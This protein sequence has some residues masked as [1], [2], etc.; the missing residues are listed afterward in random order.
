MS[1]ELDLLMGIHSVSSPVLDQVMLGITYASTHAAL[2]L[3]MSALMMC[4][5][6]YHKAGMAII[7]AVAVAYVVGDLIFKPMIARDRPC[8]LADFTLLVPIPE[9][10]SFPSGH[11]MSSF[12]AAT[13]LLMFHRREGCIAMVFAA[14]VGLSR[15][16]LFVHWPTDVLAGAFLG[17]AVAYLVV[18]FMERWI[19]SF[20]DMGGG[21]DPESV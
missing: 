6:R 3:V 2:W 11:T 18:R 13:A 7:V 9:T 12:A 1:I 14:L 10:Y 8:A 21:N 15:L 4:T 16:Y 19:P 20:R 17:I 5:R